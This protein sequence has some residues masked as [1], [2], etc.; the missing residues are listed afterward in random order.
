MKLK[1]RIF[2]YSK[3][4]TGMTLVELMVAMTLSLVI[5]AGVIQVFI[6]S[7]QSYRLND[8][9]SRVQENGR[10]AINFLVKDIRMAGFYGCASGTTPT[11]HVNSAGSYDY[12]GPPIEGTDGASGTADT[13]IIR[14]ATPSDILLTASMPL[15]SADLKTTSPSGLA[16]GDIIMV[17]DCASSDVM[18]ITGPSGTGPSDTGNV[19]HNTGVGTPGNAT[20]NL[21]KAYG[22]DAVVMKMNEFT[23]S[24]QTGA[25]GQ[26]ALFRNNNNGTAMELVEGVD[27]MQILYGVDTDADSNKVAN[28]Y[29]DATTVDAAN[30]WNNVVSVRI[31]LLLQTIDDNVASS[32]IDYFYNGVNNS[33][34]TG[35]KLRR[36][37]TTTINVRNRTL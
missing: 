37:F 30:N 32:E 8:A 23:Y 17:S 6:S 16:E 10:F 33:P 24:I 5:L 15:V 26:P 34:T 11:N 12:G 18:Q 21:S 25:S 4:Q 13:L 35:R 14:A 27:N 22:T 29:S 31:S 20:K 28:I 36:V 2:N 1:R 3:N 19:V 7:K 9:M